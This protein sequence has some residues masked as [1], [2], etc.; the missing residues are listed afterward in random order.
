MT[1]I[2]NKLAVVT[3]AASGI[4]RALALALAEQGAQLVLADVNQQGLGETA[5]LVSAAGGKAET[6]ALDVSAREAVQDF[7]DDVESKFGGADIIINN[8]GVT[9]FSKI[10][11]LSYQDF[12]WIMNIDFWGVVH[13]TKAFLPHLRRKQAGHIVNISSIFGIVSAPAQG[14]YNAA[15]FAVRGFTE[16]LRLEMRGSNIQVSCV[17]PGGVKTGIMRTARFLQHVPA[18]TRE[19]LWTNFDALPIMPPSNAAAIIVKGIRK[20]KQRI[21]VGN[22]ARMMDWIQR[23]MPTSYG[24]ILFRPARIEMLKELVDRPE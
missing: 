1:D 10:E 19:T 20:N 11:D 2:R 16:A 6:Y 8:A 4:G 23:L 7:A 22:D 9:H 15:K 14:A 13:G 12:E 5:Q 17:H 3:G 21:I 18:N 24:K